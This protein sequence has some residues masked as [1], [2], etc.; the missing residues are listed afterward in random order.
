MLATFK[1]KLTSLRKQKASNPKLK[2]I[3]LR[4]RTKL[5]LNLGSSCEVQTGFINI[6]YN[7]QSFNIPRVPG[8]ECLLHD[9]SKGI[10]ADNDSVTYIYSS[11]FFEHLEHFDLIHLLADCHRVLENQGVLRLAMPNFVQVLSAYHNRDPKF[12]DFAVNEKNVSH[13]R[14]PI[15]DVKWADVVSLAFYEWGEHKYFY[16]T[17]KLVAMLKRAGFTNI[18]EANFDPVLDVIYRE[19]HTFYLNATK[20]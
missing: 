17:E 5:K 3:S 11:H 10:P 7:S 9:L 4:G 13:Y 2:P 14:M 18:Q 12:F 1:K 20:G 8:S 19:G 16:D 6:D 15:E